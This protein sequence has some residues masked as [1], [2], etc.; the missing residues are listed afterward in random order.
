[1]EPCEASLIGD[2]DVVV[3]GG[4]PAG[5]AAALSLRRGGCSVA[6]LEGSDYSNLRVGETLP[7]AV[8]APL[9]HLG[10]W[11]LFLQQSPAMS[12]AVYSTWGGETLTEQ[13][14]FFNP[15]GA[16]WHIDR[17]QFDAMLASAAEDA[18][19]RLIKSAKITCCEKDR[20][21]GWTI[22]F[23]TG[24]TH[25]QVRGRFVLD[26][27]GRSSVM[28]RHLGV[29]RVLYD[30]LVGIVGLFEPVS[31]EHSCN[32]TT[33]V[34][35]V[36]NGWWYSAS[37][38]DSRLVVAFMTDA[39]VFARGGRHSASKWLEQLSRTVHTRARAE[40]GALVSRP[41]IVQ[42][43]SSRLDRVHGDNWLAV[44]DAAIAFDPISGQGVYRAL[45][46]GMRAGEAV[47][48]FFAGKPGEVASHANKV[49]EVFNRFLILRRKYYSQEQRWTNSCFWQRRQKD[50]TD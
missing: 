19:A 47:Q 13:H 4:G 37:L 5:S 9:A 14:H 6:I 49:R 25:S 45:E 22:G 23:R 7:P 31:E 1:M 32:P 48:A 36:E 42:A 27:T 2:Y 3:G 10:L 35:A 29:R 34:E 38:P 12:P 33:L 24:P 46:S 28:A 16:G 44:G 11:N 17:R 26:A 18:G 43:N 50:L 8:K 41:L 40:G 39:D 15:Y 20:A 30:K 21:S